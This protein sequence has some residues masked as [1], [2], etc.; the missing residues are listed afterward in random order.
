MN[1]KTEVCILLIKPAKALLT[2]TLCNNIF[3]LKFL[4]ILHV[5]IL[6]AFK[7]EPS[8]ADLVVCP[9]ISLLMTPHMLATRLN[10]S[11]G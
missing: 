9:G 6:G 7:G 10:R 8:V 3:S 2:Y 5:P 1:M 4:S 11:V